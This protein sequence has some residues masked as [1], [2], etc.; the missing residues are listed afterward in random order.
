MAN[1]ALFLGWG[2][3][4]PGRERFART[5]YAESIEVLNQLKAEGEIEDFQTVL[6]APHG[7]E[8]DGFTLIYGEP[9]KL[10]TLQM[11]DALNR[12][13]MRARLDHPKFSVIWAV[14]GDEVDSEFELFEE[15]AAEYEHQA[16][17]A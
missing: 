13:Q 2:G 5:T 12:L 15:V 3:T 4:Y 9:D 11:R 10:A 8:L 7:G 17:P 6:L 1:T 16:V 14:T